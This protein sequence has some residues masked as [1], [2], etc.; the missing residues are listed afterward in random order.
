MERNIHIN[1]T[2]MV[3]M[4]LVSRFFTTLIAVPNSRYT[5]EGSDALIAPLL[6]M[7]ASLLTVIPLL[8]LTKKF[9]QQSLHHIAGS[10][11]PKAEKLILI[12]QL[13]LC[14]LTA[15][16]AASQSEYFVAT[17]LY[18]Q[19]SRPWVIFFFMLVVWYMYSMGIEALSRVSLL[20]CGL[21]VISFAVIFTG[22]LSQID[23]LSLTKP[24]YEPAEKILTAA[25][26]YWGQNMELLLLLLLQPYS[27]K[28]HFKQD[29]FYFTLGSFLI[30]ELI[31]FFSG[32]VLGDYGKTRMY[33]IY[34]LASLSGHGF[35][36]RLDYLHII[37]WTFAC[38]LRAALFGFAAVNLLELL[39]P[40][41][42]PFLLRLAATVII[43]GAALTLSFVDGS[44][45]WFYQLYATGIP[46]AV[47]ML[48]IPL[49]L[50]WKS[51]KRRVKQ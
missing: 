29:F 25:L 37:S 46:V 50:L 4:L 17:A 13:L 1:S 36:S 24:F 43:F 49:F 35:F 11:T 18:P 10:I 16:A 7:A 27:R 6:S 12:W 39:L 47:T 5:L 28:S 31:S 51:R 32:T 26:A 48:L 14:L 44:F 3:A 2:Q 9:P 42:K 30:V 38:L 34:T 41:V 15:I 23:W 21:I 33:P 19:A 8:F 45:Q 40:K 20:V 22:V